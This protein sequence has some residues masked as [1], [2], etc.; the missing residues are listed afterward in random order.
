MDLLLSLDTDY[1]QQTIN[2]AIV[3]HATHKDICNTLHI[4]HPSPTIC[5]RLEQSEQRQ[6]D[7][8]K[9]GSDS[10]KTL[11]KERDTKA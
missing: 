6:G 3:F 5:C 7:E 11:V 8:K 9:E 2:I 4:L 10:L 1:F